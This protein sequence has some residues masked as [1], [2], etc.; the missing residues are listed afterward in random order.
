MLPDVVRN[1]RTAGGYCRVNIAR[2]DR[3]EVANVGPIE[4]LDPA[5][6][7]DRHA[8]IEAIAE[9]QE[10]ATAVPSVSFYRSSSPG[11]IHRLLAQGLVEKCRRSGPRA[12]IYAAENH[13]QAAEILQEQTW[14]EI[15]LE[16]RARVAG[17][18]RFLNT[19]IGKMSGA[20]TDPREIEEAGLATVTEADSPRLPGRGIQPDPDLAS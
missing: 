15:P 6:D 4:I 2:S 20:V 8:L 9:A 10:I 14:E 12:I 13:N 5:V 1:V 17:W 3:V 11:S 7:D 19:V 18:V 16:N